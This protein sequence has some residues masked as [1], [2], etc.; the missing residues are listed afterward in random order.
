MFDL[1]VGIVHELHR[2]GVRLLAGTDTFVPGFSLHDEL[3]L[4]VEAG[5]SPWKALRTA[6]HDAAIF[7]GAEADIGTIETGRLADLV[8]LRQSPLHNI[9]NTRTI[10]HTI[11][12][13][14]VIQPDLPQSLM[15]NVV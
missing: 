1:Q 10:A 14:H 5:L 3:A 8:V 2:A 15:V 4:L 9:A 11:I 6:T 13:G 12:A 7:L